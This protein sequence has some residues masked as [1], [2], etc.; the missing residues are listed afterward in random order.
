MLAYGA[1]YPKMSVVHLSAALPVIAR[2][3][4]IHKA[5]QKLS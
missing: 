5:N 3:F 1:D 2:V 4:Q